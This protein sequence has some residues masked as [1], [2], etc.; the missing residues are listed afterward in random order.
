M[1]VQVALESERFTFEVFEA[2][3][4]PHLAQK[5]AVTAVPKTVINEATW[6]EGA[7]SEE[8]FLDSIKQTLKKE[9]AG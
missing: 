7:V 6:V 1:A 2:M 8:V 4:F 9:A 5:Y 3:E